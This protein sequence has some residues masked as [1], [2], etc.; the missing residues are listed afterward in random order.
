MLNRS[1]NRSVLVLRAKEPFRYWILSL[2]EPPENLT[3]QEINDD[4]TVYL[5]PEYEDEG[6]IEKFLS[7]KYKDIF[8]ELLEDWCRDENYWPKSRN[9]TVFN[10]WFDVEFH[11]LAIDLVGG[12]ILSEE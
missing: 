7:K 11:S 9:R 2:P 6:D 12:E 8:E 3:L 1:I 10:K 4:N 5:I